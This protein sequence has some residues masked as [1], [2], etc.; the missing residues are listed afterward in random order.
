MR[1]SALPAREEAGPGQCAAGEESARSYQR[2]AS[3][4]ERR[5]VC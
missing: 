2:P 3:D 5:A 4:S 1:R